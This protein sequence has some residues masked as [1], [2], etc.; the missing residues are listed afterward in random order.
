MDTKKVF[1][2]QAVT[3]Q[4]RE[5]LK[6]ECYKIGEILKSKGYEPLLVIDYPQEVQKL[7]RRERLGKYCFNSIDDCEIYLIILRNEQKSEGLLMEI[8]HILDKPTKI[9][10]LVQKDVKNTYLREIADSF[11]EYENTEDMLDKLEEMEF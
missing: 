9:V 6:M 11:I 2:G 1:I 5:K 3:G 10:L 7:P 4:D 8:G